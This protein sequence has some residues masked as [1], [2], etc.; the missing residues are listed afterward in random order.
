MTTHYVP[1]P[2]GPTADQRISVCGVRTRTGGPRECDTEAACG[3]S[4]LANV[5]CPKCMAV[6]S[7]GSEPITVVAP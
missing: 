2:N 4:N 5:D 7:A 3:S 6:Y 1:V